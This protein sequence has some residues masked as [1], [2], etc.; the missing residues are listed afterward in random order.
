MLLPSGEWMTLPIADRFASEAFITQ[1]NVDWGSEALLFSLL[2]GEGVFLDI[3]AHIGYYSLYMLPR[4]RACYCFE[5]GP[6]V[7][8]LLENNVDGIE[9]V[10]VI[11][12]A[13]GATQGRARFTL[14][15]H[16]EVSHLSADGD[17]AGD[18]I[19]VDV[20]TIDSF[21]ADRLLNVE[22]IKIDIEGHDLE[23]IEGALKVMAEQ[24]PLVL[25]EARP[26]AKLF[27]LTRQVGYRVFAFVRNSKSGSK[28]LLELVPDAPIPGQTKMLFLVPKRLLSKFLQLTARSSGPWCLVPG[29]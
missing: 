28:R 23:A 11:P 27:E 10:L 2:R 18:Q 8:P 25:T 13:V 24:A 9:K 15:R 7:L 12:W 1:A 16:S 22:A 14:E 26:D 6:R 5:P 4:V 19:V 20:V 3:G 21:I 29:A 17:D